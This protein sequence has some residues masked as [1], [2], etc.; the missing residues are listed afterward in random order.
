MTTR[1][2]FGV[3]VTRSTTLSKHIELSWLIYRVVAT[4]VRCDVVKEKKPLEVCAF[5]CVF[6]NT[7]AVSC[8]RIQIQNRQMAEMRILV[9]IVPK[10][11][12]SQSNIKVC[13]FSRYR[14]RDRHVYILMEFNNSDSL[15]ADNANNVVAKHIV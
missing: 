5:H 7:V 1:Q 2:G 13:W 11:N 15:L 6:Q 9:N 14:P 4:P 3:F 12:D 8:R 10:E